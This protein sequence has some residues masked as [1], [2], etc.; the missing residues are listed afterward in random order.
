MRRGRREIAADEH[1]QRTT[2]EKKLF[3]SPIIGGNVFQTFSACIKS[4]TTSHQISI[5]RS[6][7]IGPNSPERAAPTGARV[8][9]KKSQISRTIE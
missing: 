8:S 3:R 4:R 2:F 1:V 6:A 5:E 9:G 7:T